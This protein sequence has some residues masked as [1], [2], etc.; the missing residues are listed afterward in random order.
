MSQ[1]VTLKL[2]QMA[3]GGPA[4]GRYQGK[5]FFVPYALP[6][7][8]V[9]VEIETSKKGWARARLREVIEPSPE[10]TTPACPHFGP[11]AC[12]GCQWQH[13]DYPAQLHYKTDVVRDQLARLAGLNDAP[14]RPARA[15]GD[16]WGYRNHVQLHSSPDGLGYVSADG[17]RVEPIDTCPIMHPLISELY[18]ELDIEIENLERLSL[19][20]GDNT[21]QQLVIFETSDDEPFELMVDLPISCALMLGDG[22]PVTLVGNDYLFERVAGYQYRVSAGSFFQVNTGGAEALIE[23]VAGYLAPRPHQALLD[24]YCGVGLFSIALATR[25]A[26]VIAVEASPVAAADAH[27]NVEAAGLD[28]VQVINHDVAQALTALDERI[29][30]VIADPPRNGCGPDVVRR[31][32]SLRSERFVYVA[33]DP[34]TLARD[35]RV[36]VESGYS[37]V[38]VQPLDLFPQTYHIECVALFVR[39]ALD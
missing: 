4:M 17:E 11:D 36:I 38:E 33:C 31:L 21:G 14:V 34:A 32:A 19:R 27:F 20:A 13:I 10:R 37:L 23:S 18:G 22:T 6:G 26:Q 8:T 3:H 24:L 29:H 25:V 7:E 30:A 15:V 12:G 1:L 16:P 9:G 35:A 2:T 5:V 28:N 39:D